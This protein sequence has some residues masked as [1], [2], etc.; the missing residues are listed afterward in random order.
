MNPSSPEIPFEIAKLQAAQVLER[1]IAGKPLEGKDGTSSALLRNAKVKISTRLSYANNEPET[2]MVRLELSGS[3]VA[4]RLVASRELLEKVLQELPGIKSHIKFG[5]DDQEANTTR[6]VLAELIDKGADVPKEI[7]K[8]PG[9]SHENNQGKKWWGN[10]KHTTNTQTDAHGVTVDINLPEH[11]NAGMTMN[12]IKENLEAGKEEILNTLADRVAKYKGVRG[13]K[14]EE[15]KIRTALAALEFEV[16]STGERIDGENT[17]TGSI[18]LV[19]RSSKQKEAKELRERENSKKPLDA[20]PEL[21]SSNILQTIKPQEL[22]KAMGRAILNRG[23]KNMDVTMAIIGGKDVYRLLEKKLGKLKQEKPDLAEKVDEVLAST[24]FKES[25]FDTPKSKQHEAKL[26]LSYVAYPAY[27]NKHAE[28]RIVVDIPLPKD[29]AGKF[30]RRVA[31]MGGVDASQFASV[32]HVQLVG[33]HS[34]I[35]ALNT[36]LQLVAAPHIGKPVDGTEAESFAQNIIALIE[37]AHQQVVSGM[38]VLGQQKAEAPAETL[39][40]TVS[41]PAAE[42]P[43]LDSAVQQAVEAAKAAE[44]AAKEPAPAAAALPKPQV[45]PSVIVAN[46]TPSIDFNKPDWPQKMAALAAKPAA[47]NNTGFGLGA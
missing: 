11:L 20:N 33:I 30:I 38:K 34:P 32:D 40:T 31:A 3:E 47:G 2:E 43:V 8:W 15:A 44:M 41:A 35:P 19:F 27:A 12:Q 13:N 46:H 45:T 24:L 5:S 39:A 4:E 7:L 17:K 25:D 26:P 9:F 6:A 37:Q 16:H 23:E 1:M 10:A 29:E 18:S 36:Q 21:E 22:A 42:K 28:D 14:E